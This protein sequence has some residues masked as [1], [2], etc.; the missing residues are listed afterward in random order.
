MTQFTG[1]QYQR[2]KAW[3]N[4]METFNLHKTK[5]P[6]EVEELKYIFENLSEAA[7]SENSLDKVTQYHQ[8]C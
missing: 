8:D 7:K 4:I 3:L 1:Q 2:D 6:R 5:G